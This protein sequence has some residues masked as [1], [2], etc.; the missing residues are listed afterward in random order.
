MHAR[1][2]GGHQSTKEWET[3]EFNEIGINR[4]LICFR[5]FS[6]QFNR[7]LLLSVAAADEWRLVA[8]VIYSNY[9]LLNRKIKINNNVYAPVQVPFGFSRTPSFHVRRTPNECVTGFKSIQVRRLFVSILFGLLHSLKCHII[10]RIATFDIWWSTNLFNARIKL[11]RLRHISSLHSRRR[12]RVL[13]HLAIEIIITVDMTSKIYAIEERDRKC[14]I[15]SWHKLDLAVTNR[16]PF[17]EDRKIR[18]KV[19]MTSRWMKI[20]INPYLFAHSW[21]FLLGWLFSV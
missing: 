16:N 2:V 6:N 13:S 12:S 8:A 1:R 7:S 21:L 11:Y 14:S 20:V 15:T 19:E 9:F 17:Q 10:G 5:F 18:K 4:I 3:L